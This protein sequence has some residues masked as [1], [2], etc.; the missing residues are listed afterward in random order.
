MTLCQIDENSSKNGKKRGR[1]RERGLNAAKLQVSSDTHTDTHPIN[2]HTHTHR[3]CTPER[4][5]CILPMIDV[6]PVLTVEFGIEIRILIFTQPSQAGADITRKRRKNYLR[7][8]R[9]FSRPSTKKQGKERD[10]LWGLRFAAHL[11]GLPS[12]QLSDQ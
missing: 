11:V 5:I 3:T 4:E 1:K 12:P 7:I 8:G 6:G 9:D 10:V 2:I